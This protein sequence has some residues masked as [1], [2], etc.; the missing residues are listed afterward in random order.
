MA[1]QHTLDPYL[2][3]LANDAQRRARMIPL[4]K[5]WNYTAAAERATRMAWLRV[6]KMWWQRALRDAS[7]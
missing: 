3:G 2:V 7:G 1:T 6:A 5:P 4:A